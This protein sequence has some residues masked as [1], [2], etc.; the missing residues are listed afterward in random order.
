MKKKYKNR[1]S[2]SKTKDKAIRARRALYEVTVNKVSV[3]KAAENFK[4]SY[5]FVQRRVSGTVEI[6]ARHCTGT[7]FN[8]N[9]EREFAEYLSE[10]AK[11]GLG[12]RPSEFLDMVQGIVLREERTTSLKM[13]GHRTIGIGALWKGTRTF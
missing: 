2:P 13:V 10:M 3:R 12:L 1:S 6:D 11:R 8:A 9:E 7:V 5:G 4:L